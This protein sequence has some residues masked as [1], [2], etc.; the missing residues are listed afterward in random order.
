MIA[1]SAR[2]VAVNRKL[3]ELSF[4]RITGDARPYPPAPAE[5]AEP[6][7]GT[8]EGSATLSAGGNE[9]KGAGMRASRYTFACEGDAG[10]HLLYNTAYGTFAALD[11][12]AFAQ[13]R[14]CEGPL[15]AR[16]LGDLLLTELTPDEELAAQK[17]LFQTGREDPSALFL[18]LAPTYACNFRCPYCYEQ[19]HNGIKGKMGADVMDA[20]CRFVQG[21]FDERPFAEMQ[22]QWYGG[23]PSLALD[24][25]EAL[26]RRLMSW[27]GGHGVEYGAM[28]LT[29]CN[30]IDDAAARMLAE[31]RVKWVYMTIDGFEQTHNARRVSATGSNSY[32]R[33]LEA[34]RLFARHGIEA[35][36]TMN[37][38][39]VN[40]PEFHP[41]RD[42]LRKEA[43]LKL[44]CARLCDYGHFFG[45][46]D[47]KKPAFDLFDHDEYVRL[48][49]DEFVAGGFSGDDIRDMLSPVPRFCNGQRHNYYV[50]DTV[51]DVYPC[52]GYIG[53]A[54]HVAFNVLDGPAPEH[55]RMVSHDPHESEQCSACHLLPICRG[56]CDWERRA[57]G[58]VCHPLLTT[59]PDYLRDWRSCFGPRTGSYERLC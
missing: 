23:D 9:A 24:V 47:F 27:C 22:V 42:M 2:A 13:F 31:A 1:R 38:D 32:A 11:D 15:A 6:T 5:S 25:V 41:L 55:L 59:L 28:M 30:N 12:A 37:V 58:M 50:I 10:E 51:G 43:D 29:N 14:A 52:D 44:A 49:H 53:E 19:G 18:V 16:M 20:I 36:A 39:R 54:G 26:S 4:C 35:R 33:N 8:G 45:A 48:Q 3:C 56:N 7:R 57:T 17:A 34:A 40:W 21:R 46:R